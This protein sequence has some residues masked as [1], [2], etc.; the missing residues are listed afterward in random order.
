MIAR[1]FRGTSVFVPPVL[2]IDD[3]GKVYQGMVSFGKPVL[4]IQGDCIYQGGYA[5]GT[6]IA[7]VRGNYV[8]PGARGQSAPLATVDGDKAYEGNKPTGAPL[9]TIQGGDK[10]DAAV[11]AVYFLLL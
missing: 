5:L 10:M 7:T 1:V 8:Y 3:S 6:P 4:N 9:A 11:A 2:T